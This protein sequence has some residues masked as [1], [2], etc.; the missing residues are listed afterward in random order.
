MKSLVVKRG[1]RVV[2]SI[3]IDKRIL[4][5]K[6]GKLI[7]TEH[8]KDGI[9]D[10]VTSCYP[11]GYN[12]IKN[13]SFEIHSPIPSHILYTDGIGHPFPEN[14]KPDL[15]N[16][17]KKCIKTE[18]VNK[19]TIKQYLV[20]DYLLGVPNVCREDLGRFYFYSLK[21]KNDILIDSTFI[22]SN[23]FVVKKDVSDLCQKHAPCTHNGY[24]LT[25]SGWSGHECKT[26]VILD[27]N[28]E[29]PWHPSTYFLNREN[30]CN[31]KYYT[32]LRSEPQR[33]PLY[34]SDFRKNE[35]N[36][37]VEPKTGN[38]FISM[39]KLIGWK[40]CCAAYG[41]RSYITAKL[42]T[43]L[44]KGEL[45]YLEFWFWKIESPVNYPLKL[46]FSQDEINT[47]EEFI[48]IE[49]SQNIYIGDNGEDTWIKKTV[50][51]EAPINARYLHFGWGFLNQTD[52]QAKFFLD[53]FVL[54]KDCDKDSVQPRFFVDDTE[55]VPVNDLENISFNGTIV[56]ANESIVL[57]NIVFSYN[58]SVLEA[59][60]FSILNRLYDFLN[61]NPALI[62]EI[63]GHT[64]NTGGDAFN[65]KLSEQRAQSVCDYLI[66]NGIS[67][68]RLVS[69]GY[70]NSRPVMTNLTEDGRKQNRR[71]EMR[72][73]TE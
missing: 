13:G 11:A 31:K 70:G 69:V 52:K 30:E 60:S 42:E 26:P 18:I 1:S 61:E 15:I 24:N 8:F 49:N 2:D 20:E 19:D 48:A 63:S 58:S 41:N 64:D 12:I 68:N 25:V 10:S 73:L 45:Y 54:V 4:W 28:Q 37:E 16:K 39:I 6:Q 29:A 71:V 72:I 40:N 66:D 59:S 7:L 17:S 47:Y 36:I 33:H 67:K 44:T 35:C 23:Q 14:G 55:A 3:S 62:V 5:D 9:I 22:H 50:V 21:F 57:D 27:V 38:S 43:T 34:Y 46:C 32:H 51:F 53:D 65:L 56:K